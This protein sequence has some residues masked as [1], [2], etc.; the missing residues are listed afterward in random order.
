MTLT[1]APP[2][3]RHASPL[4]DEQRLQYEQDGFLIVRDFFS[5]SEIAAAAGEADA[6]LRRTELIHTDNLRCRWTTD[7]RDQACVFET[8]DPVIDL[9]PACGRLAT[10]SRL[11][12][13]VGVL[14]GEEA[15]LFKDKLIFKPPG[16]KGYNLHQ[17]YI[18]WPSF[19]KTFMTVIVPID[20]STQGNGCTEVFAGYH[21]N[22]N[23]SANDGEYHEL[24]IGSVEPSRAVKLEL[25]P[26]DVV[27]FGGFTPHR[28]APNSS[29][30][31]R[32]Q[33]YLSYNAISDGGHQRD[34]HYKE[35]LEWLRKKYADYGKGSTYFR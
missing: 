15:C 19:P 30:G 13:A 25:E 7:S 23:L 9:A 22:G 26:G 12:G 16:A 29:D 24:P 20:P 27:F 10:D 35:F 31:Y 3:Q 4:S 11:L 18:S 14:Y 6:L 1:A 8:F 17:D 21:H 5:P 34:A 33:L 28:S 2:R 32:R